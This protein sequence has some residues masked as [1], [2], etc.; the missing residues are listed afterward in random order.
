MKRM[1]SG[2][3]NDEMRLAAVAYARFP[4]LFEISEAERVRIGV[5]RRELKGEFDKELFSYVERL[6][7]ERGVPNPMAKAE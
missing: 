4:E 6:S 1:P 5:L 3:I 7:R 2:R